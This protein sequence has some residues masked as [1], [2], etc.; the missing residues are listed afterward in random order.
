MNPITIEILGYLFGKFISA[1]GSKAG[2]DIADDILQMIL[3]NSSDISSE[4]QTQV[5]ALT[6]AVKDLPGETATY[7]QCIGDHQNL[8]VA[9]SDVDGILNFTE[10]KQTDP[11]QLAAVSTGQWTS[12]INFVTPDAGSGDYVSLSSSLLY[13][14]YNIE[15][16]DIT[17]SL[18]YNPSSETTYYA[19][20]MNLPLLQTNPL[21]LGDYVTPHVQL[22]IFVLADIATL[23]NAAAAAFQA[24]QKIYNDRTNS[25]SIYST[26]PASQ[27]DDIST[28]MKTRAVTDLSIT[29]VQSGVPFYITVSSYVQNAP[30]FLC[31][32][33]YT[34]FANISNTKNMKSLSIMN[35][36]IANGMYLY[37]DSVSGSASPTDSCF[38]V[39]LMPLSPPLTLW[40]LKFIDDTNNIV[41]ISNLGG[42]VTGGLF[43]SYGMRSYVTPSEDNLGSVTN[44]NFSPA[45]SDCNWYL[46]L[47]G[48]GEPYSNTFKYR[49]VNNGGS[50]DNGNALIPSAMNVPNM[51]NIGTGSG[52]SLFQLVW[53]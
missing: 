32:N 48:D 8:H 4:I 29:N 52:Q 46:Q 14:V 50:Y 35:T 20:Q 18:P 19:Y 1:A 49:I 12:I 43:Y 39:Y 31:S 36:D 16:T 38:V 6:I 47:W 53:Q 26:L 5:E 33:A 9:I 28:L 30:L 3:G 25:G 22:L 27:Q 40:N 11:V 15:L 37:N 2:S 24:V 51:F 13:S 34:D 23:A 7:T 42:L 10:G 17:D 21:Y 45:L 44:E 41:N